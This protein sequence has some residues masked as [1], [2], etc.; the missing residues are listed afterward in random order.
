MR[1][2]IQ[3]A[4]GT[5]DGYEAEKLT[6][7]RVNVTRAP[8]KVTAKVGKTTVKL[9]QVQT[10]AD[11]EKGENVYYYDAEPNLNRFST[12]GTDAAKVD[13]ATARQDTED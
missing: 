11:F 7:L 12:P 9:T 3:P 6:E 1:V 8:K 13:C 2:D 5:Y 4:Q 10:L